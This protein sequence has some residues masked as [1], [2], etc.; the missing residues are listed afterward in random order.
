M[1]EFGGTMSVPHAYRDSAGKM[2]RMMAT[3]YNLHHE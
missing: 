3:L 2:V 1:V